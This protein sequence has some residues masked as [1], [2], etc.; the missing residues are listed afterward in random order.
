[1]D[2]KEFDVS[3][4]E[5]VEENELLLRKQQLQREEIQLRMNMPS[6][7]ANRTVFN[8]QTAMQSADQQQLY[9][10]K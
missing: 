5:P 1:M 6:V 10:R 9:L 2:S 3:E 4:T 8:N 7:W